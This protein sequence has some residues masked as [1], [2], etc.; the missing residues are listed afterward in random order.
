[1]LHNKLDNY[2][3]PSCSEFSERCNS[4]MQQEYIAHCPTLKALSIFE[5]E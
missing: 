4:L 3:S 1:M 5:G 2:T